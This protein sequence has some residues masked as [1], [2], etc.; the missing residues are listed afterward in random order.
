MRQGCLIYGNLS[1]SRLF[2]GTLVILFLWVHKVFP[3]ESL[4]G[5]LY[6]FSIA[7]IISYPKLCGLKE[8]KSIPHS[9]CRLRIQHGSHSPGW[10]QG[11]GRTVVLTR[12]SGGESLSASCSCWWTWF[13]GVAGLRPLFPC[14][15]SAGSGQLSWA[16][17]FLP[18]SSKS[19]T[20]RQVKI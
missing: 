5:C 16:P 20:A 1:L 18:P 8:H 11:V 2:W 15:L 14:W 6:W 3:Q 10:H 12:G 17:S 19:A 13:L 7:V 9:F 4:A